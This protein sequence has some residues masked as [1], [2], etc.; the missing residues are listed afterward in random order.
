MIN[1]I[2]GWGLK[3]IEPCPDT[4]NILYEIFF[5]VFQYK[6]ILHVYG[7]TTNLAIKCI[8]IHIKGF[9]SYIDIFKRS[10]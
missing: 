1:V 7:L 2:Y 6:Y 5:K 9:F 4:S 8:M 10:Y 3:N